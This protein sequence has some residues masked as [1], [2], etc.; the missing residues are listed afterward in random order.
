MCIRDRISGAFA[1]ELAVGLPPDIEE[2]LP[3]DRV[4][5]GHDI[6]EGPPDLGEVFAGIGSGVQGEVASQVHTDV[7]DAALHVR[8]GPF[9]TEGSSDPCAA[10]TDHHNGCRD[11]SEELSLIH[12]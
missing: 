2:F 6:G 5:D 9:L 3:L 4:L 10:V 11:L 1:G 8:G 7:E 12:I